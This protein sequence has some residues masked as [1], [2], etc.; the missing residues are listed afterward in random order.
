MIMK[1]SYIKLIYVNI[2]IFNHISKQ[3]SICIVHVLYK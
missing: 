3:K 2:K 1:N